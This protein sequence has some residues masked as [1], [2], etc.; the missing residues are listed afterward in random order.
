M[1]CDE[2]DLKFAVQVCVCMC[3]GAGDKDRFRFD[4]INKFVYICEI[5]QSNYAI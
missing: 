5:N 3:A 1:S 4:P 2:I